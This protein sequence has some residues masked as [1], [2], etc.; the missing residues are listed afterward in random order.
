MLDGNACVPK[1]YLREIPIKN[2]MVKTG[3]GFEMG[4]KTSEKGG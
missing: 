2:Q 4:R 1:K 3:G